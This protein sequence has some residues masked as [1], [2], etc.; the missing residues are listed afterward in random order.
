VAPYRDVS[1]KSFKPGNGLGKIILKLPVYKGTDKFQK[2]MLHYGITAV[3]ADYLA[4][5]LLNIDILA[6]AFYSR[7]RDLSLSDNMHSVYEKHGLNVRVDR[8]E[9]KIFF[10]AA[11]D[12]VHDLA[13]AESPSPSPSAEKL[14]AKL[15]SHYTKERMLNVNLWPGIDRLLLGMKESRAGEWNADPTRK[16]HTKEE[17]LKALA[18][19]PVREIEILN[20]RLGLDGNPPKTLEETG[21]KFYISRERARVLFDRAYGKVTELLNSKS[22]K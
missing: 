6:S 4:K 14:L 5:A 7:R 13:A 22:I 2:A 3:H 16:D 10:F 12:R 11:E 15:E 9:G 1:I 8:K 19:L 21:S 17:L 20:L 18:A